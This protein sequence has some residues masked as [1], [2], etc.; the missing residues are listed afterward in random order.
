MRGLCP[1]VRQ[2]AKRVANRRAPL[3]LHRAGSPAMHPCRPRDRCSSRAAVRFSLLLV[4]VQHMRLSDDLPWSCA[5]S[6]RGPPQPIKQPPA[7]VVRPSP[8]RRPFFLIVH[9]GLSVN[10]PAPPSSMPDPDCARTVLS[11]GVREQG[12]EAFQGAAASEWSFPCVIRLAWQAW[13]GRGPARPTSLQHVRSLCIS[14][15]TCIRISPRE[16]MH[17]AHASIR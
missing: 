6:T 14:V 4:P 12:C 3:T 2:Q 15:P 9:T 5:T 8:K 17:A 1:E 11:S 13:L 10:G 7:S 16:G